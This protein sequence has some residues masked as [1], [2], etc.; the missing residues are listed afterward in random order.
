MIENILFSIDIRQSQ[1]SRKKI[2]ILMNILPDMSANS[3]LWT[4]KNRER[5]LFQIFV[6]VW[7][8]IVIAIRL[9][10][11]VISILWKILNEIWG[12][13]QI[14]MQLGKAISEEL[15]AHGQ[16][17]SGLIAARKQKLQKHYRNH[18][19]NGNQIIVI[20]W[21]LKHASKFSYDSNVVM[22]VVRLQDYL[23]V[24]LLVMIQ[25]VLMIRGLWRE[26][27]RS[28]LVQSLIWKSI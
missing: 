28:R 4:D 14:N 23:P 25:R 19:F 11:Q 17:S 18:D 22:S 6:I 5:E 1:M 10:F 24:L 13:A 8:R 26:L 27:I 2:L 20:L 12:S 15:K 9:P 21:I 7:S 16:A 3:C